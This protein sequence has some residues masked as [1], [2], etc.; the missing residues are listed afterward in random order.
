[1]TLVDV[2]SGLLALAQARAAS[3]PDAPAPARI[4]QGDATR[5]SNH[6][7]LV[8]EH[9]TFDAVLLLGP[10]YHIMSADLRASALRDAWDFVRPDGG[11]L[12]CAWV[13]RY[14]HYRDLAT[15]EP[16]RLA[17]KREFY[18]QHAQDGNYVKLGPDGEVLH[19][20]HHE[21]PE[22][23]PGILREATGVEDVEMVGT[24][25]LLAGGLDKMVN[26]LEGDEFEVSLSCL[27][28]CTKSSFSSLPAGVGAEMS[29]GRRERAWLED[30]GSYCWN[31][32]E[33]VEFQTHMQRMAK[34]PRL[35]LL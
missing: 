6:P 12:F 15:R 13:S 5:L 20:M 26:E 8:D 24:E 23:M 32:E 33:S 2:S 18:A 14:A 29:R 1:M 3:S 4:L 27:S 22:N 30:V 11:V 10:L 17:R 25:G 9:G 16:A 35:V 21:L 7:D 19:A 28:I 34:E 31:C